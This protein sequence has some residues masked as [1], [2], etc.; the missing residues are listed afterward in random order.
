MDDTDTNFNETSQTM[1]GTQIKT[2]E[3]EDDL[4]SKL[5][6]RDGAWVTDATASA[7]LAWISK[8]EGSSRT[9]YEYD[10]TGSKRPVRVY[11]LD[12]GWID[13]SLS[14]SHSPS[15]SSRPSPIAKCHSTFRTSASSQIA[16]GR[17]SRT[18]WSPIIY[19]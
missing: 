18:K 9:S 1:H 19:R 5:R 10:N 13:T 14:V 16:M 2:N 12:P 15:H 6:E 4:D 7:E 17:P 8:P 11:L 3:T